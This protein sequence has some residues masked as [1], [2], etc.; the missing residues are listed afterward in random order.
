MLRRFWSGLL[1]AVMLLI[2]PAAAEAAI[3]IDPGYLEGGQEV[4]L[5]LAYY[6]PA[7]TF[8]INGD[9][10]VSDTFSV[11]GYLE[12]NEGELV[13]GYLEGF[14]VLGPIG[15]SYGLVQDEGDLFYRAGV[16]VVLGRGALG[17]MVS[18]DLFYGEEEAQGAGRAVALW[19][20][21]ENMLFQAGL[22]AQGRYIISLGHVV[23]GVRAA[24]LSAREY[25]PGAR[26][27]RT[28]GHRLGDPRSGI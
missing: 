24:S 20:P 5:S 18:G 19:R 10:T 16:S 13:Y 23:P 27:F 21:A 3:I 11:W 12:I 9:W 7:N 8:T 14:N 1:L 4:E 25:P 26:G 28:P 6:M 17:G 22:Y 15:L 2:L